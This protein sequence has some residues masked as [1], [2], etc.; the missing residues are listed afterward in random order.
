MKLLFAASEAVG[1]AKTGGLADVVAALPQAL[2][3]RGHDCTLILPLYASTR[4]S[5]INLEPLPHTFDVTFLGRKVVGRL[6]Q[7]T[8]DKS[9]VR[10]VL[11]RKAVPC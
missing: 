6:F 2:A 8:L 10:V 9:G 11:E 1:F 7:T 5:S 3:E 4:H